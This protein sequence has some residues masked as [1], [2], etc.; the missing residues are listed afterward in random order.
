M[1]AFGS[2]EKLYLWALHLCVNEI[3]ERMRYDPGYE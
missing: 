2:Y 3:S 1:G